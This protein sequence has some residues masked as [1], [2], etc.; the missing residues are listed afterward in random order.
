M[1]SFSGKPTHS[2]EAE[3]RQRDSGHNGCRG[4]H[5]DPGQHAASATGQSSQAGRDPG[6]TV[7]GHA[8]RPDRVD[9]PPGSNGSASDSGHSP[10]P[11]GG[12]FTLGQ[13]GLVAKGDVHRSGTGNRPNRGDGF[14]APSRTSSD[15]LEPGH[16]VRGACRRGLPET[17]DELLGQSGRELMRDDG[18]RDRERGL[19]LSAVVLAGHAPG[20]EVLAIVREQVVARR[21]KHRL[22]TSHDDIGLVAGPVLLDANSGSLRELRRLDA[23]DGA[24]HLATVEA[25]EVDDSAAPQPIPWWV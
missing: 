5:R 14:D 12:S 15:G 19:E 3:Q 22:R 10:G 25:P 2:K 23:P 13:I 24:S 16:D 21:A 8:E 7:A 1:W 6:R 18:A 17:G 20:R 11:T 9:D 4:R